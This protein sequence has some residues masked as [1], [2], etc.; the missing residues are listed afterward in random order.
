[1]IY[2]S[3]SNLI[4]LKFGF[5]H[6]KLEEIKS[7]PKGTIYSN[8]IY[9]YK[10]KNRKKEVVLKFYKNKKIMKKEIFCNTY[11]KSK[12][13]SVPIIISYSEFPRP[14]VIMDKI[15]GKKLSNLDIPA[16]VKD[17]ARVHINSLNDISLNQKIPKFTK[18][19]RIK[20]LKRSIK[21]LKSNSLIV[22]DYFSKF[23][24]LITILK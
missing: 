4:N 5:E 17:L 9:L 3:N 13:L 23:D 6:L 10:L 21:I 7:F 1:M 20:S 2:L 18:E 11:L 14:Y 24:S 12:G 16:R 19:D 15:Q 22:E 8:P